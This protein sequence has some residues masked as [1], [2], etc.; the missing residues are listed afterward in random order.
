MTATEKKAAAAALRKA[1]AATAQQVSP[2]LA[3]LKNST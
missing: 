3:A 1:L 2:R